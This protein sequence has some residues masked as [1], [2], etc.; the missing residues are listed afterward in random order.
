V[1]QIWV[2]SLEKAS[3]GCSS[4]LLW[5][6]ANYSLDLVGD[7]LTTSHLEAAKQLSTL[8]FSEEKIN[9]NSPLIILLFCMPPKSHLSLRNSRHSFPSQLTVGVGHVLS[10]SP[11][12]IHQFTCFLLS[13]SLSIPSSSPPS[14]AH[15]KTSK[16]TIP[17]FDAARW[18][19]T[20]IERGFVRIGSTSMA[21]H[22]ANKQGE[23]SELGTSKQEIADV[24]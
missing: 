18:R 17:L 12:C 4:L 14:C 5:C 10:L 3:N 22:Q 15:N 16:S 21:T 23:C 19:P 8:F 24:T 13:L 11:S 2:S 9:F 20:T 1:S 7:S 6:Y